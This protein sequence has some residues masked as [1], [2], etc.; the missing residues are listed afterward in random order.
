MNVKTK[1][2]K[3]GN[4]YGI[5]LPKETLETL[6]VKE[7]DTLYLTENASSGVEISPE[8]SKQDKMLHLA[9]DLMNRYEYTLRELAK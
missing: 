3:I 2:R 1:V 4:S 5:I 8:L 7:G 9:E 6:C